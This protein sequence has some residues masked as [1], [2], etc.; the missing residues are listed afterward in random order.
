V[1]KQ[2]EPVQKQECVKLAARRSFAKYFP[3]YS[4]LLSAKGIDALCVR[5]KLKNPLVRP[6]AARLS[7]SD[8]MPTRE[9]DNR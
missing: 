4:R 2:P 6:R 7:W 1:S 9:V 8:P 3:Y 5:L